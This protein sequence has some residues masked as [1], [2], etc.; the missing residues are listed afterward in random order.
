MYSTIATELADQYSIGYVPVNTRPDGGF[1]REIVQIITRPG[2]F[3]RTR[4]GYT[5]DGQP[6]R[7]TKQEYTGCVRGAFWA[8]GGGAIAW[9]AAL[10]I[11]PAALHS[12]YHAISSAASAI[13]T[14]GS[15][16]CHQRPERSF[17]IAGGK[18]PVCARCT[19]LY[20]SAALAAPL[21]WLFGAGGSS[22]RARTVFALA[23]LPTVATWLL[24]FSGVMPFSNAARAAAALPLGFVAAW[25]VLTQLEPPT[26]HLP[27]PISG[28]MN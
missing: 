4:L 2:L 8:V 10:V 26:S 16:I 21:V 7:G 20:A 14:A 13:Y 23:A 6:L 9:L 5:V 19:G 15:F 28:R 27:P 22:G 17:S 18:M 24:E 11:A 3:P 25:L 12:S 1:R